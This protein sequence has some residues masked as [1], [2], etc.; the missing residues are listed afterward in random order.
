[1]EDKGIAVQHVDTHSEHAGVL[2]LGGGS[3]VS[4]GSTAALCVD[5]FQL[6]DN[7]WSQG[8]EQQLVAHI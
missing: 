8:T 7:P 4:E 2:S 5:E 1:M 6:V 3:K